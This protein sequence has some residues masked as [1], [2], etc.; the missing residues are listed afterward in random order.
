MTMQILA[1]DRREDCC[2]V[3]LHLI[4][5]DVVGFAELLG[6]SSLQLIGNQYGREMR[7]R[8]SSESLGLADVGPI[9]FLLIS[10]KTFGRH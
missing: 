9:R 8:F 10:R 2:L 3:M 1:Y 6:M 7:S 4:L 5:D